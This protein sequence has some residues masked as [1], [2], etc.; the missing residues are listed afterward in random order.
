VSARVEVRV[1]AASCTHWPPSAIGVKV[2]DM[3]IVLSDADYHDTASTALIEEVQQEYIT[4]YGGRDETPTA[5][6]EFGPP[7]GAFVVVCVDGDPIACGGLRRHDDDTAEI[8][9]MYVRATHRGTGIGLRLLAALEARARDL[10]Y[11]RVVLE[12]GT[13]QPEAMALYASAGYRPIAPYGY[14]RCSA[15]SRCFA[16]DL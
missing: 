1:R 9:R 15:Q 3:T 2:V 12:T 10:G 14:H 11:E 5:D 7:T 4:R 13:A 6:G 8:K 16:K